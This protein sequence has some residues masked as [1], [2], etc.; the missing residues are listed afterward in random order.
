MKLLLPI[1]VLLIFGFQANAADDEKNE[2]FYG[3]AHI[4]NL[5]APLQADQTPMLLLK[6]T[7]IPSQ[8]LIV[9]KATTPDE[10]GNMKDHIVYMKVDG[11]S[12]SITDTDDSIEGTGSVFGEPWNW[13]L[14]KFSM[15]TKR[16][17]IKIEDVN[18]RTPDRLIA[19]KELSMPDGK[20]FM[21]WD[22]DA[23]EITEVEYEKLYTEMHA[24]IKRKRA[25]STE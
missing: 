23:K 12:L 11:H 1:F 5:N 10:N 6:K 4:I 2:Y 7:T 25:S 21:L 18:Y 20:P 24:T 17:G 3:Q 22:V 16:G 9:E 8:S 15:V 19:R 13:N 14:L